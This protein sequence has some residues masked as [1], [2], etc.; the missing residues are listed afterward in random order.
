[1]EDLR[2]DEI[3]IWLW[4]GEGGLTAFALSPQKARALGVA[5]AVNAWLRDGCQG[6]SSEPSHL[7]SANG[8]RVALYHLL[9]AGLD[10]TTQ[11]QLRDTLGLA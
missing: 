11:A 1:M 9:R 7:V 8:P 4:V 6:S 2:A 5:V 10:E 3:T